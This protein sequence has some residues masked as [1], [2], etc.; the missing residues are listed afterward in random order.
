MSTTRPAIIA[1]ARS[2]AQE[3]ATTPIV[4]GQ[5]SDYDLALAIALRHFSRDVPN[6]RIVHYTV[7]AAAFRFILAGAG[8]ILTGLNAWVGG[9]S[10][11]SAVWHPYSTASQ[12]QAPLDV[13]D[14]RVLDEPTIS[15][16]EL[17]SIAP[18]SGTL[19]LEFV[20]PH[21]VNQTDVAL[22]SVLPAHVEALQLRTAVEVLEMAARRAVQN[23]GNSGLPTDIVDRRSQS[24]EYHQRAKD[25]MAT[26]RTL[27]GIDDHVGPAS[28]TRE[29]D[30]SPSFAGFGGFLWKPRSLR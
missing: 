6:V 20:T 7:T 26:Y 25:L 21:T 18:T 12:G 9:A 17:L 11:M 5:S 23:T 27:V 1:A 15:V 8:A 13:N 2:F 16:L 28:A 10:A 3:T 30:V 29:L 22:T 24:A 4:A 14:W 19:R